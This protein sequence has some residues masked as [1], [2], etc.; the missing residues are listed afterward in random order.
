LACGLL[1]FLTGCRG[2]PPREYELRG[3]V[4]AVDP[5]R[6]EI[7]IAHQDIPNFMPGMT[8]P[9][10]VR[11]GRLLEGRVPGDLVRALLVVEEAGAFLQTLE[12]VGSAPL[13]G[14]PP[15]PR[16]ET[17][18]V[19]DRAPDVDLVDQAGR[20]R[21]LSDWRGRV[22]AVTFVYTRCPL[23][24]FCP[25]MDRHFRAAQAA[26]RADGSLRGQV[27]LLSVSFD[28]DFDRPAVLA[29]HAAAL[30]ADPATWSYATGERAAIDAFASRFG[31]SIVREDPDGQEIVHN[32]RTA[33]ID[34]GGTVTAL[35]GG[36]E[37]RAEE[38]IAELRKA[39]AAR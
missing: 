11:D 22:V 19:G 38:L 1:I 27:H 31:V 35:L 20:P 36:N 37:W 28:P 32:L 8:M 18:A 39:V 10:K 2:E 14:P 25:L 26:V 34:R 5:A 3:Q 4:L 21:R 7:T 30:G 15:G 23:P 33:V 16:G 24:N 13:G 12:R 9:F 29:R 6:Q 17:L